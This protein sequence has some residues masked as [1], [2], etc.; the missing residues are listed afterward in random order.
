MRKQKQSGFTLIEL[1]VVV[2]IIIILSGMSLAAYF[3]FSQNQAAVNDARSLET[4]LRRVQAMAKNLIYPAGC[5]GLTGYRIYNSCSGED[6]QSV[7]AE[8]VC[9]VGG[10]FMVIDNEKVFEKASFAQAINVMFDAGSGNVS[11]PT[12]FQLSN[13]GNSTISIDENGNIILGK[14]E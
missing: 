9:A 10:S 3:Q 11:S 13:I 6:C 14:N 12:T 5:S 2:S 4:M 7:S 8:A 1:I